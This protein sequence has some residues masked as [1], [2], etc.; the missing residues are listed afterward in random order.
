MLQI[1]GLIAAQYAIYQSKKDA[2][3]LEP[4]NKFIDPSNKITSFDA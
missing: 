3:V 4:S 1:V 2:Q